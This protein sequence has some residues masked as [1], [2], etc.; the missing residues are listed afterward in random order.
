MPDAAIRFSAQVVKVQTTVDYGIRVTLEMGEGNTDIAK[1]LMDIRRGG[2]MLEIAAVPIEKT[3]AKR[4]KSRK[5]ETR[6]DTT[7]TY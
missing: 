5:T 1:M 6:P 3:N 4:N 2:G 7:A